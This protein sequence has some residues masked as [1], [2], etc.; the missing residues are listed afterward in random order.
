[1][2][3]DVEARRAQL[4]QDVVENMTFKLANFPAA[5]GSWKAQVRLAA[6]TLHLTIE[7]AAEAG[8]ID[9]LNA[10]DVGGFSGWPA[11]PGS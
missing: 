10:I 11:N 4:T 5:S 1:M 9:G 8:D 3:M 2:S 6:S 7:T